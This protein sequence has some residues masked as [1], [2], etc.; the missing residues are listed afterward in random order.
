MRHFGFLQRPRGHNEQ[1]GQNKND[2]VREASAQQ[3]VPRFLCPC[4]AARPPFFKSVCKEGVALPLWSPSKEDFSSQVRRRCIL[5]AAILIFGILIF[6]HELGHFL[7][8]RWAGVTVLEFSIGMGPA[9]LKWKK[10]ETDYSLR[11]LPIG[12]YVRM[13]GEEGEP[14]ALE[15]STSRKTVSFREVSVGRRIVV[16]VAG[17]FMN[18]LLALL[19][20]V[21]LVASSEAI[22]ST[23]VAEYQEGSLSSSTGLQIDDTILEINGRRIRISSDVAYALIHSGGEP[24]EVVVLRDG[25]TVTLSGVRFPIDEQTGTAVMDFYVYR[26]PFTVAG[27]LHEAFFRCVTMMRE[28]YWSIGGMFTGEVSINDL[29]GPV[30]TTQAISEISKQGMAALTYFTVFISIN[31]GIVNLLPIPAL[32][33]GRLLL[34]VI[35]KLR[36]KPIPAELEGSINL[37]GFALL[38]ML[39]IFVTWREV[40]ALF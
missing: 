38:M 18:L 26:A 6:S 21:A 32:D 36:K 12:G 34:L 29:S 1:V 39:V 25:Q 15:P 23:T 7:A 24:C 19:V 13:D 30:G 16:V 3:R 40:G 31:L 14:S 35:E 9:L 33:G 37:V 11:L 28:I 2:C 4:P 22:G 20:M 17:A 10:G 8:A 27:V 5:I